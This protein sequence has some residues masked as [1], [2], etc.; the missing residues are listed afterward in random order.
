MSDSIAIA[1]S[2]G[3]DSMVAACLLKRQFAD[4]FAIHFL[5]GFETPGV[6]EQPSIHTL[7]RR[8][9][10]PVYVVDLRREF[11]ASVVDYF[12]DA[13]QC[14]RTPNPCLVCN[15]TI[16]FGVLLDRARQLGASRLA[17]GH[18]ARIETD[19]AGHP[20]LLKGTDRT[21]DQSYFLSRL[22]RDQLMRACFPL[23]AWTKTQVKAFAEDKGLHPVNQQESQDVC[24]IRNGSYTE[25]L[26]RTIALKP[27]PGDIVDADGNRLGRHDGLHQFTVGQRRGINIPAAKPYYVLRLDPHGNRLVVGFREQLASG[28]CHVRDINWMVDPPNGPAAVDTR[29]RYRHLAVA[30]TIIPQ[31]KNEAVVRFDHPQDAVTPGQ[32]AVFYRGEEVLGGGWIV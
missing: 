23:G 6:A 3:I 11:K 30:S 29:I 27:R 31:G 13:Y 16:K 17:T 15:P 22:T 25:F 2:G 8:L 19:V 1:V 9:D 14:G 18:Y 12:T 10:F 20:R 24:F 7:G 4:L 32:G 21:K 26:T 5:T 28:Q